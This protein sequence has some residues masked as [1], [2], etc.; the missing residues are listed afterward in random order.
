MRAHN[1]SS[2]NRQGTEPPT[3]DLLPTIN[4]L[5]HALERQRSEPHLSDLG[6]WLKVIQNGNLS[7]EVAEQLDAH[8]AT[9]EYGQVSLCIERGQVSEIIDARSSKVTYKRNR[10][11]PIAPYGDNCQSE[12][13]TV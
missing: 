11:R 7:I 10:R 12:D 13:E 4:D 2:N 9:I 1:Q 6:R 8:L 5:L 3:S